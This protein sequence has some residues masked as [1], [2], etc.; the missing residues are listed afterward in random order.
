MWP[1]RIHNKTKKRFHW[2]YA[3]G[4]LLNGRWFWQA[5]KS[6]I[7]CDLSSDNGCA[8]ISPVLTRNKKK[9]SQ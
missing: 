5:K 4:N 9:K 7:N 3:Y 2:L 6:M 1:Q 8:M